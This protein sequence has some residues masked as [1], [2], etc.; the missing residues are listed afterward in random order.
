MPITANHFKNISDL[1]QYLNDL[2]EKVN[3]LEQQNSALRTSIDEV[4]TRNREM[5]E[6]LK[7]SWPKTSLFHRSFWVR[8]LTIF[9]HNLVIQLIIGAVFFILYLLLLAPFVA[10]LF[11]QVTMP[12]Q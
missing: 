11:Q 7:E 3:I 8:A 4:N 9:G 2:E 5:V 12:V 6:F 10:Q 1:V